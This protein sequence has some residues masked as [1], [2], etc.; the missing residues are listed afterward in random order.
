[1]ENKSNSGVVIPGKNTRPSKIL[2]CFRCIR[3]R[4]D[5]WNDR[6]LFYDLFYRYH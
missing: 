3:K 5:L 6:N 4:F 2:L 1:M